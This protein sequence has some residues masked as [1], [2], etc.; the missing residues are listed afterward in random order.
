M[1]APLDNYYHDLPEPQK[2]GLLFLRRHILEFSKDISEHF[3]YRTAFFHFK[4]KAFCYFSVR[5]KDQQAYIGFV[6][7]HLLV[8]PALQSEGRTQI[9]VYYLDLEKDLDLASI[10]RILRAALKKS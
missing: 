4:G 3:K 6:N 1:L 5:K 9:K 2:S 10:D 7:G 8:H